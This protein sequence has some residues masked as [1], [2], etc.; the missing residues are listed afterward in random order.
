MNKITILPA[1][2]YVVVNKTIMNDVDRKIL[3][4]LYQ[5]I[6]GHLPISLYFS[7]WSDLDKTE[8]MSIEYT[9]HHLMTNM[10][11]KLEEIEQARK[12]LEAIG[13]LK[14]Y[15]KRGNINH[16]IY[17]LYSP[18]S[19]AD[20][21]ND[22]ILNVLLYSHLGN[23]EYNKVL[24]Y[25]KLPEIN[26]NDYEDITVR[27]SDIFKTGFDN[28][29]EIEKKEIKKKSSN[30]LE[31]EEIV[32][33]DLIISS[34]PKSLLNKRAF[35]HKTKELINK[36]NFLYG[37]DNLHLLNIIRDCIN[38]RGCIDKKKLRVVC[39]N[40]YQ[41]EHDDKLPK[42]IYCDQLNNLKAKKSKSKREEIIH[43]FET[44][45]PYQFLNAKYNDG[46]PTNRDKMLLESLLVE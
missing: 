45:S 12:K 42:L 34:I 10:Q 16:Y 6:I 14:V 9:H 28:L 21:L 22:P 11:L 39:R 41:F 32:D 4:M 27:F 7:L 24:N 33:F 30:D 19:A 31:I 25:F 15:L 3:T 43:K 35:D 44:L 23:N 26:L 36:L 2:T 1:D 46:T 17:Q 40:Y 18:L 37:I 38:E 5:P 20:F 8:I 29:K 13:L